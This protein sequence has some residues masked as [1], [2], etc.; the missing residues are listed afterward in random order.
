MKILQITDCHLNARAE[1][2]LAGMNTERTLDDVLTLAGSQPVPDFILATGDIANDGNKL[3]YSKF[4]AKMSAIP[5]PMLWLP[6]NHD[7]VENMNIAAGQ[8]LTKFVD[9]PDWR[10]ILLDSHVDGEIAGNMSDQELALLD[11]L[12]MSAGQ[13]SIALFFHHPPMPVDCAWLDAQ[14]IA[15]GDVLLAMLHRYP[16]VQACFVGHVHQELELKAG[17]F[18]IYTTPS[19]CIQF[20]PHC[21]DFRLDTRMPG[22]RNIELL[23]TGAIRTAVR[24][25]PMA[26]YVTDSACGCY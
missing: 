11:E 13:R 1:D 21:D 4:L 10:L 19:T 18:S 12:L 3:A 24:R 7:L 8:G 2:T 15:N 22:F 16:A 23:P 14:Q 9:T 17:N 6:G 25:V 26:D 5:A 20:T